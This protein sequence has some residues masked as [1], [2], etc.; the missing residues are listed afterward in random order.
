MVNYSKL[1]GQP[2]MTCATKTDPDQ[3]DL[4]RP[5]G[6]NRDRSTEPKKNFVQK[7]LSISRSKYLTIKFPASGN[8]KTN[9]TFKFKK[10]NPWLQSSVNTQKRLH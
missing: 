6:V 10:F 9:P 8:L 2:R 1:F 4:G 5:R 3:T 7:K